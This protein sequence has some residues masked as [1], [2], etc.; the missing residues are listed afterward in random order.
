V[1]NYLAAQVKSGAMDLAEAQRG[2]SKDWTQYLDAAQP[3][4]GIAS[5]ARV[6]EKRRTAA[7]QGIAPMSI[8]P[9]AR[10]APAREVSSAATPRRYARSHVAPRRHS[11][12]T[13]YRRFARGY[14]F[15]RYYYFRCDVR[16]PRSVQGHCM[17]I[18]PPARIYR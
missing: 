1:E 11:G 10:R 3:S 9:G 8:A 6:F 17:R 13:S 15:H 7:A 12:S 2:I 4:E 18:A 5:A 14:H 16:A